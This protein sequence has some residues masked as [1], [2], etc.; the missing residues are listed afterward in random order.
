MIASV[1]DQR[2]APAAPGTAGEWL[3][4]TTSRYRPNAGIDVQAVP[5]CWKQAC[6]GR[7][8]A[9]H[10]D[11]AGGGIGQEFDVLYALSQLIENR[12]PS[13]NQRISVWRRGDTP[14][15]S[16]QQAHPDRA[17]ELGNR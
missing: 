3:A 2:V 16:I 6:E 10:S 12:E 1:A 13:L 8:R 14:R 4:A 11:F 9:P 17:F 15:A 5:G 7:L